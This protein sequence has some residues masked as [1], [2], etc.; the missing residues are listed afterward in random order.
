MHVLLSPLGD[1]SGNTSGQNVD[2]GNTN[3]PPTSNGDEKATTGNNTQTTQNGNNVD[4]TAHFSQGVRTAYDR[5]AERLKK[6]GVTLGQTNNGND[7]VLG[8]IDSLIQLRNSSAGDDKKDPKEEQL[9]AAKKLAED[10]A[11]ELERYK[12]ETALAAAIPAKD[13]YDVDD[14]QDA[15]FRRYEIR[16]DG[17]SQELKVW[18]KKENRYAIDPTTANLLTIQEAVAEVL[19]RKP[20][21]LLPESELRKV[22]KPNTATTGEKEAMSK[23][24]SDLR[25]AAGFE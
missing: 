15:F 14:V 1:A 10:R 19:A 21:L 18:D 17:R 20:Q 6:A 5:I 13:V 16:I 25:K 12:V 11:K 7:D 8:A 4:T 24:G 2:G 23:I 3:T 22:D 9:E